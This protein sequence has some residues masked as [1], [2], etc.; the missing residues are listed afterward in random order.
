MA[1]HGISILEGWQNIIMP[2]SSWIWKCFFTILFIL[3]KFI[4]IR[5]NFIFANIREFD[6]S[7]IQN[8]RDMYSYIEFA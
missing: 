8:S 2:L 4:I 3:C 1:L 6:H 5:E 7:R